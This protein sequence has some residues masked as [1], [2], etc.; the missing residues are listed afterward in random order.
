[1]HEI[2]PEYVLELLHF[3]LKVSYMKFRHDWKMLASIILMKI[4]RKSIDLG[5]TTKRTCSFRHWMLHERIWSFKR[6]SIRR[7]SKESQEC[8]ER[9]KQGIT[10][11]TEVPMSIL[12][13]VLNLA[14]LLDTL[15]QDEDGYTDSNSKCKDIITMLLV[16]S[17]NI[18]LSQCI[19]NFIQ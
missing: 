18:L 6:R 7:V 14:R 16:E 11:P 17:V 4:I 13:R 9:H 15:F 1:M 10:S 19:C 2:T 5:S 8:V 12:E 3:W